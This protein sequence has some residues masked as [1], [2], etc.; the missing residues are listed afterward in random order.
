MK[1]VK[2]ILGAA[3]AV[4][5]LAGCDPYE[6]GLNQGAPRLLSASAIDSQF[7]AAVDPIDVDATN[8]VAVLNGVDVATPAED[9]PTTPADE[10]ADRSLDTPNLTVIQ[11]SFSSSLDGRTVQARPPNP[12][13]QGD[14]GDCTPVNLTITPAAPAGQK[15]F[16]CYNPNGP[17]A[18]WARSVLVYRHAIPDPT[19]PTDETDVDDLTGATLDP[20]VSY[21]ITGTLKS[22]G[23][24]DIPVDVTVNTVL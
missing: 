15:W 7:S 1:N 19:D 23:G 9:D 14:V 20:N 2:A 13:V 5:A 24:V 17:V 11:L 16:T 8:G 10:S 21:R 6:S 18:R 12:A 22:D 4:L 3:A